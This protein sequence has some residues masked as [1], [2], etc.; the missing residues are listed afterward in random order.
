VLCALMNSFAANYLIRLRVNTHV[1]VSLVSKLPMPVVHQTDPLFTRLASIAAALA[2]APTPAE[3][4]PTYAEMQ[5]IVARL[6]GL[7]EQDLSRVLETFPLIPS[8]VRAATMVRF[9]ALR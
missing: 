5:A 7:D 4:S 8:A 2:H 1:T 3:E 9:I 6:Y